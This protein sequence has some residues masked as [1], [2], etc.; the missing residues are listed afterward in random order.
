MRRQPLSPGDR[1][2]KRIFTNGT[3]PV[4]WAVGPVNDKV[5]C[6][7]LDCFPTFPIYWKVV[8][9]FQGEV[10]YHS[11]RVRESALLFDFGRIPQ[12]NC[13]I[14]G[15]KQVRSPWLVHIPKFHHCFLQSK[16]KQK[17]KGR[18]ATP[19]PLQS[20]KKPWFIPPIECHEPDDGV[21]FAQIGPTGGDHGYQAITGE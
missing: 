5:S 13:P 2:D 17:G 7:I 21:Y 1:L 16:G 12:W 4:I 9:L 10:S 3:Q 8:P 18:T 19:A 6:R 15:K 14:A 20:A 11:K